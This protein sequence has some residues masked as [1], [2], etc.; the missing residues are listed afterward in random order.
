MSQANTKKAMEQVGNNPT[1]DYKGEFE[2]AQRLWEDADRNGDKNAGKLEKRMKQAE[3]LVMAKERY[4]SNKATEE[5]RNNPGNDRAYYESEYNL[6]SNNLETATRNYENATTPNIKKL[7]EEQKRQ[8]EEKKQYAELLLG[9][10]E[11]YDKTADKAD[12]GKAEDRN[13]ALDLQMQLDMS[14][15]M[16]RDGGTT[17]WSLGKNARK[18]SKE[19]FNMEHLNPITG[20]KQTEFKRNLESYSKFWHNTRGMAA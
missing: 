12:F 11:K 5:V 20:A 7:L 1:R 15:D 8:A 4:N 16:I 14:W 17:N 3:L 19:Y 9:M 13:T 18:S 10:K 6:A 2:T